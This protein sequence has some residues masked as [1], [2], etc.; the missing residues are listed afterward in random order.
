VVAAAF[1]L[2][3]LLLD[4][5]DDPDLKRRREQALKNHETATAAPPKVPPRKE[6]IP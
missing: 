6:K 2:G 3:R 1:H 5:P 4:Q